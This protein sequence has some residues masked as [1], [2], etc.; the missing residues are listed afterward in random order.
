MKF[1]NII[2]CIC[3]ESKEPDH[4]E[5]GTKLEE[6]QEDRDRRNYTTTI[7]KTFEVFAYLLH[8]LTMVKAMMAVKA[9]DKVSLFII[10]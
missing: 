3:N 9:P 4:N 1:A 8:T 2:K 7:I 10:H 6:E 5:E